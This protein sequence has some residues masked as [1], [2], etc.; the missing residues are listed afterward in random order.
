MAQS[1]SVAIGK[2]I[3]KYGANDFESLKESAIDGT[4]EEYLKDK[5]KNSFA[6]FAA[7]QDEKDCLR[8][9]IDQ[10]VNLSVAVKDG[11]TILD[12]IFDKVSNPEEFLSDVFDSKIDLD[13]LSSRQKKIYKLGEF[14]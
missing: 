7:E 4:I 13:E 9:L 8:I 10:G 5:D 1:K 6:F 3:V 12:A 2:E 11:E 14:T